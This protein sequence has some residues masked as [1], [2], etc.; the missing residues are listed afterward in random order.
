MVRKLGTHPDGVKS[1]A[2]LPPMAESVLPWFP[3]S[4]R[5]AEKSSAACAFSPG[6][7]GGRGPRRPPPRAARCV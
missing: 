2:V 1:G 3:R 7:G 4:G 5:D 6:P